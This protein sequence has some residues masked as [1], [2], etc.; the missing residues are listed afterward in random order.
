MF[1]RRTGTG[2]LYFAGALG[3]M[4][5]IAGW[6]YVY[7]VTGLNVVAHPDFWQA[8]FRNLLGL[9]V[10]G[11]LFAPLEV[12]GALFQFSGTREHVLFVLSTVLGVILWVMGMLRLRRTIRRR[13]SPVSRP[14]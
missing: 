12:F 5:P 9:A 3:V 4:S 10:A 7:T 14:S 6:A 11:L 13:R 2:L 8:P 1:A